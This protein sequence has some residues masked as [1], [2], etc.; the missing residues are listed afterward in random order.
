MVDVKAPGI[1]IRIKGDPK[2]PIGRLY[3]HHRQMLLEFPMGISSR[4]L[5]SLFPC[6]E[7]V[8]DEEREGRIHRAHIVGFEWRPE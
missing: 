2:Y 4:V 6:A 7:I 1:P 5:T 8:I 3:I